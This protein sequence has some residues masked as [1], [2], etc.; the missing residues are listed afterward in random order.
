MTFMPDTDTCIRYFTNRNAGVVQR[1][2]ATD[3]R[4]IRICDIV[5]AELYYGAYKSQR[6]DQN[7][8]LYDAFFDQFQSLHFDS[9]AARQYGRLRVALESV[10]TPI[11]PNDFLIAAIALSNNVILV[12]HNTR[13]FSRVPGLQL[14]DWES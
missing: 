6:R 5:K 8:A 7:L 12:T 14:D 1:M 9:A 10:G 3:P 2:A 13:E 4:D 11:G